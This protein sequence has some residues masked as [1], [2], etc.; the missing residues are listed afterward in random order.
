MSFSVDG[1]FYY[2]Y[3]L[4]ENFSSIEGMEG[5]HQPV[6]IVIT[7]GIFSEGWCKVDSWAATKGPA[8]EEIFPLDYHVDYVRLYQKK[9]DSILLIGEKTNPTSPMASDDGK[10][11]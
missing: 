2:T 4:N 5:F 10:R 6:G 11:W 3:N 7:N 9:E 8:K 1:D